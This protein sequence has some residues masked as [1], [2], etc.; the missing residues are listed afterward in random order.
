MAV[1]RK[2]YYGEAHNG[3]FREPLLE[4]ALTYGLVNVRYFMAASLAGYKRSM[5][6][7]DS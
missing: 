4:S 5:R 2:S 6:R 3:E 1:E 7:L